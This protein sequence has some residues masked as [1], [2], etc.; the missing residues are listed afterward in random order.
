VT[1]ISHSFMV[2]LGKAHHIPIQFLGM[3]G[4]MHEIKLLAD[5]GNDITLITRETAQNK[6]GINP[7]TIPPGTEFDVFGINPNQPIVAKE[8]TNMIKIGGL[9][10]VWI[11]MGIVA[12]FGAFAEDLLGRR[13]L[14]DNGLY[15]IT[16]DEDSVD[17]NEKHMNLNMGAEENYHR[18]SSE[19]R[20][21]FKAVRNPNFHPLI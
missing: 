17:F 12:E 5:T 21:S 4:K 19:E 20:E 9:R 10:P 1:H 16:Y 11:P 3:D 14:L 2:P 6:L 13:G 15:S 7:D 18:P 8:I